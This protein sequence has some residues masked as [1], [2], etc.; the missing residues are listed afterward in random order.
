M[1]TRKVVLWLPHTFAH[2]HTEIH[3]KIA[4]GLYIA[5]FK[6]FFSDH[7]KYRNTIKLCW[8][9]NT[10]IHDITEGSGVPTCSD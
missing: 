6:T 1:T 4:P 10:Q 5:P 9:N 8:R 3:R 2:G 7:K